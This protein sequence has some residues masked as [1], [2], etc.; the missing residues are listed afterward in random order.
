MKNLT[1][2]ST[3]ATRKTQKESELRDYVII[4]VC[5][6]CGLTYDDGPD[7]CEICNCYRNNRS[8]RPAHG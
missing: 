7:F 3:P 5:L 8:Q 1:K 6:K 4:Y 2:T